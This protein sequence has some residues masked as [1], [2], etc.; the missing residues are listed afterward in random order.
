MSTRLFRL[1]T[2]AQQW[3]LVAVL[4]LVGAV[5]AMLSPS[6]LTY[7][8]IAN[9]ALQ[10]AAGAVAAVGMT[11]VIAARGIDL[12]IGSIANCSAAFAILVAGTAGAAALNVITSVWVYPVAILA[13]LLLGLFNAAII[14]VFRVTPLIATLGTLTL[15]RGL[16]LHM[17]EAA[18]IAIRGSILD[19]S[20]ASFLGLGLPVWFALA[21]ALLGWLTLTQTIFGRQVLA[22]GRSPRSAAETGIPTA[23]LTYA[24]Y[25][26]SGVCGAIAGLITVGR[27]GIIDTSLGL[28]FEFTVITAV[29]LGG[30]SLFGGRGSIAGAMTGALLLTTID[31]GLNLIGANPFYYQVV[32]GLILL[33]AI[34]VDAMAR[35]DAGQVAEDLT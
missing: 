32:R 18:S 34:A 3:S 1:E 24:V 5:F 30:T 10:A 17:T 13:G 11:L 7:S 31:N 23:S 4:L 26:I 8:N 22:L 21:A 35:R 12:S 33:A 16:G 9:I 6:F 15:Y 2:N 28:D 25:G 14:N 29:V 20:R 27:V 19:F